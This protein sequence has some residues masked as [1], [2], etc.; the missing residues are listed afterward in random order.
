VFSA[1]RPLGRINLSVDQEQTGSGEVLGPESACSNGWA[2][3]FFLPRLSL[4]T[5]R[6]R[7]KVHLNGEKLENV[8]EM[9]GLEDILTSSGDIGWGYHDELR[10]DFYGAFPEDEWQQR[11]LH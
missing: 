7:D 6:N 2:T 5:L 4:K 8:V 10:R 1:F 9:N 11:G 3:R